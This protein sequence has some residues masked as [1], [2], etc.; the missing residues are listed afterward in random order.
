MDKNKQKRIK[1]QIRK[2]RVRAKVFGTGIRPRLS[3]F[4]AN[5]HIYGQIIN[6]E[7]GETLISGSSL[8]LK[9]KGK[10][11][12]IAKEVGKD[13]AKKALGKGIK[14]VVF[15]RGGNAYHGRIKALAEGAREGGLIF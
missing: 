15:D 13:L 3:I 8:K 6:D 5:S 12:D 2:N 1:K 7:I 14:Q 4:R 10:K 9:M 11:V